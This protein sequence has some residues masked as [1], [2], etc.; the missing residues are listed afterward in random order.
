VPAGIDEYYLPNQLSL[1][2][3]VDAAGIS[4]P[5]NVDY[6][7]L[8]K[9]V[10]L[11]QAAVRFLKRNYNLDHDLVVTALVR[12]G[13]RQGRISW[14]DWAAEP[15][16]PDALERGSRSEARFQELT[17][18]LTDSKRL[19][20]Y[21]TDFKDWIYHS[22]TVSVR[23]NEELDI[24]AG[25]QISKG[26]FRRM[27]SEAAEKALQEEQEKINDRYDKK[28]DTIKDRLL[29]E[30]R[31]LDEDQAEHSQ[32][33]LEE[34]GT[35]AENL[36]SLLAGRRR[37]MT[38]SLT[39]R[40]MTSKAKADVEESLEMIEQYKEEIEDLEE[41]R[42]EDLE[43]AEENWQE[44]LESSSDIP[45][46]PYKKDI[47]VELYGVAWMPFYVYQDQGRTI[48]LAAYPS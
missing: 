13:D 25:P 18:P 43:E 38:T 19:R 40:R 23:V 28:L 15:V 29:R 42:Q 39:K 36:I 26:E 33:K 6:S 5:G 17:A 7:I 2:Q 14:E 11:A 22:L 12:E 24:Y 34:V 37:R 9:P 16:D 45:V 35:H 21:E 27:C 3:A 8:Y 20:E 44:V 47:L 4:N 46:T 10:L 30:E 31:E 41:D 48:E 32:R 1:N